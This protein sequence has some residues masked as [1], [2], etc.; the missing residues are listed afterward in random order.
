MNLNFLRLFLDAKNKLGLN[1]KDISTIDSELKKL[2]NSDPYIKMMEA[3]K[4]EFDE[5]SYEDVNM[6]DLVSYMNKATDNITTAK[7]AFSKDRRDSDTTEDT[8]KVYQLMIRIATVHLKTMTRV[9][10]FGK[11]A[12]KTEEVPLD[13]PIEADD[14]KMK[15]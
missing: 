7:N 14:Q 11:I 8:I 9:F 4:E 12:T 13:E 3:K 6:K 15:N 10:S 2:Q 1:N 5:K